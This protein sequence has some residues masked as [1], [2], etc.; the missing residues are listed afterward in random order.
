LSISNS[1]L[2]NINHTACST[3]HTFSFLDKF[4][5]KF[6]FYGIKPEWRGSCF[7][8]EHILLIKNNEKLQVM[9][10]EFETFCTKF[11][12]QDINH[13][14]TWDME[15]FEIGVSAFLAGYNVGEMDWNNQC[16]VLKVG[17]N[18]NN[19]EKIKR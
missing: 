18:Y 3:D 12:S 5:N 6:K 7:P 16:N 17:F 4:D 14:I 15:A 10:N 2:F 8:S 9:A 13:P 1:F 19:W 11:E